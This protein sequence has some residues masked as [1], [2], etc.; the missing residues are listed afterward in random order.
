MLT[1]LSKTP[2]SADTVY[3]A[4]YALASTNKSVRIKSII[5]DHDSDYPYAIG[6][7]CK[8][9]ASLILGGADEEDSLTTQ[10]L[11][12]FIECL[13]NALSTGGMLYGL[14]IDKVF[15]TKGLWVIPNL[16]NHPPDFIIHNYIAEEIKPKKLLEINLCGETIKYNYGKNPPPNSK[17]MAYLM[18]S[19][20][21]Y[22][23]EKKKN[24]IDNS[25]CAWYASEY[26]RPALS[27]SV[28]RDTNVSQHDIEPLLN[29][30]LE[31]FMLF[32]AA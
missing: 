13:G 2:L 1:N 3:P 23:I 28:G 17:L 26:A 7:G 25:L 31:S 27:M 10:L 9:N 18:A 8:S 30:L 24:Y 19:S 20:C 11:L 16:K 22:K 15:A 6:F 5:T 4:I 32:I 29:R 14:N 12:L 21:G